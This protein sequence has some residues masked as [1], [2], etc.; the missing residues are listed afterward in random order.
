VTSEDAILASVPDLLFKGTDP[1]V[2]TVPLTNGSGSGS[3][4]LLFR[5]TEVFSL[6]TFMPVRHVTGNDQDYLRKIPRVAVQKSAL[7]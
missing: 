2:R 1:R 3:G 4:S 7:L 6:S 5:Q